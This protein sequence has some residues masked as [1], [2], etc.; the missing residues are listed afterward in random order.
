M[1]Q[2]E[3]VGVPE[4]HGSVVAM[5]VASACWGCFL[6]PSSS[7]RAWCCCQVA[8]HG[9]AGNQEGNCVGTSLSHQAWL[10]VS[11]G[12]RWRQTSPV[13]FQPSVLR[14]AFFLSSSPLRGKLCLRR[15]VCLTAARLVHAG[16]FSLLPVLAGESYRWRWFKLILHGIRPHWL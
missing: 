6:L 9:L 12:R 7:G 14:R 15:T 3:C 10:A 5:G 16:V 1:Q 13:H 4:P 11:R 2:A 8:A